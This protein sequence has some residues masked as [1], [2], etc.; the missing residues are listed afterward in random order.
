VRANEL[1]GPRFFRLFLDGPYRASDQ[2]VPEDPDDVASTFR[3][4][5]TTTRS[6]GSFDSSRDPTEVACW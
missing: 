3:T 4:P 6:S 2:V 1:D 5:G